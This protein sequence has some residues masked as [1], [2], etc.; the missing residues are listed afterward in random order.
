MCQEAAR[1]VNRVSNPQLSK[2]VNML[3]VANAYEQDDLAGIKDMPGL[4][5]TYQSVIQLSPLAGI[6]DLA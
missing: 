5:S 4:N 1:A 6:K 2:H 3:L